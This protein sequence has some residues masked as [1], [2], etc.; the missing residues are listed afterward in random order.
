MSH[1]LG[2][3]EYLQE[4]EDSPYWGTPVLQPLV[5]TLHIDKHNRFNN[6]N[7]EDGRYES[8]APAGCARS[9]TI[10]SMTTPNL[11]NTFYH[12]NGQRDYRNLEVY[13]YN[14]DNS[15]IARSAAIASATTSTSTAIALS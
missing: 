14:A 8:S 11:R 13:R 2:H 10:A 15:A 6:Y 4:Q 7:V 9:P 3:I 12:Y 5:G 1:T